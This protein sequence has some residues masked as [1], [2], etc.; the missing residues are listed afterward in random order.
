VTVAPNVFCATN[1]L[2]WYMYHGNRLNGPTLGLEV[3][4]LYSGLLDDPMTAPREDL[5]TTWKGEPMEITPEIVAAG[6]AALRWMVEEGRRAGMPIQNVYAHRQSHGGKPGDPGEGL[7][8]ALVV[9]YAVP[10][11]GLKPDYG[12]TVDEGRPIPK[13]WDEHGVGVYR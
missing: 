2:D 13:A 7:W 11:L 5:R 1:P 12:F 8:R 10:V 9:E 6:R 4:G 3:S